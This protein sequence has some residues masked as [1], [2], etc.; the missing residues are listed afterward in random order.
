MLNDL[1][2]SK[3]FWAAVAGIAVVVLKDKLPI[4]LDE[5]QITMIVMAIG[6]W[7]VGDSLRATVVK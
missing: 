5:Q 2:K 7:I 6:S 1:I 4:A 3:R